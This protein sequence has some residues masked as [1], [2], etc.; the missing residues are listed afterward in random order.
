MKWLVINTEAFSAQGLKQKASLGIED[1]PGVVREFLS[2]FQKPF[3]ILDESSRI[4]SNTPMRE[5]D[6]SSRTRAIK[7]LNGFGHRCIMTGTFM[8]KSPLNVYDQYNFLRKNFFSETM[9]QF[10]ERYCIMMTLRAA[11]GRRVLIGQKDYNTIRGQFK[12]AYA[13]GGEIALQL[14]QV[15]V[16]HQLGISYAHQEHIIRHKEYSPFIH[17]DELMR[18]IAPYTLFVHRDD[19]FDTKFDKHVKEPVMLPVQLTESAKMLANNL[20]E[21]GFTDTLTLGKAPALELL[22]RLQDICNGFKPVEHKEIKTVKGAETEVRVIEYEPLPENPK[23]EAL[24][25][26]LKDIDVTCNQVVVWSSRTRLLEACAEAFTKAGYSFVR[27]DGSV[28]ND[29][30]RAAEEAF[31]QRKAQIFLA[32]QASGAYGLNCLAQCEHAVFICIDNSV[33]KYTQAQH[34][35]LRGQLTA[36]KYAYHVYTEGTVEERQQTSLR[37]GQELI[38]AENGKEKFLFV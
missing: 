37:V 13:S 1:L 8:S 33:E 32:N 7:L 30:K 4:K 16:F 24:M 22:L 17:I 34:R 23:I 9:W 19:V 29:G 36:P 11:R 10:A 14:V 18:R 20:V 31:M 26:L 27:Y 38:N 12:R 28:D 6:K 5:K 15:R 21:L 2:A 25:K 35:I 3:I